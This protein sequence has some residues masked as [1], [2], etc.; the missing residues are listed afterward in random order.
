VPYWLGQTFV[1]GRKVRSLLPAVLTTISSGLLE[2][3]VCGIIF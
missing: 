3:P 1:I 2:T